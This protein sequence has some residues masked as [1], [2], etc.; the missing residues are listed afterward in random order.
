MSDASPL[1]E[2]E[3]DGGVG[4]VRMVNIRRKLPPMR[5]ST[6]CDWRKRMTWPNGPAGVIGPAKLIM[7]RGFETGRDEMFLYE[8]LGQAFAMS[9]T[10]FKE[11]LDALVEKRPA[12]FKDK[13]NL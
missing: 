3:R 2:V 9:S 4:I 10:E 12:D 7:A 6:R 8:G 5:S 1:M 11:R 13:R